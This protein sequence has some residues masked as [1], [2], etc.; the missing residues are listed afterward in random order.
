M[1]LVAAVAVLALVIVD[2]RELPKASFRH[3]R[4]SG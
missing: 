2:L 1:L 4:G 3:R